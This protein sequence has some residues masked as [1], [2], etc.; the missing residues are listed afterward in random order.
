MSHASVISKTLGINVMA[1]CLN[2]VIWTDEMKRKTS[3]S[4]VLCF[5]T[6]LP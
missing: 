5:G 4:F 1:V 3:V 6:G 2:W